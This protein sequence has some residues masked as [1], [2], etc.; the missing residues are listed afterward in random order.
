MDVRLFRFNLFLFSLLAPLM[1]AGRR[2]LTRMSDIRGTLMQTIGPLVGIAIGIIVV[3]MIAAMSIIGAQNSANLT[4]ATV[5]IGAFM[6]IIGVGIGLAAF[7]K[8]MGKV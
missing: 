4:S 8:I 5:Q 7:L 1:P 2:I 3:I 6:G